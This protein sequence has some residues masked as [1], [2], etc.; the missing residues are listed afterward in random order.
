MM[1]GDRLIGEDDLQAYVDGRLAPDRRDAVEVFLGEHPEEAERIEAHR[2]QRDML[3]ALLKTKIEEPI[4][5][6][7]RVAPIVEEARSRHRRR[8]LQRLR[9]LAAAGAWLIVGS[10]AGWYGKGLSRPTEATQITEAVQTR[11]M[12]VDAFSAYRTFVS[13]VVHP[14]EVDAKQEA[15][16][17]QWLSKRLGAPLSAPN[18][19][20]QGFRLMGGRLLPAG[21]G[22][23]AMFMYDD[24]GGTRLTLYV[25]AGENDDTA[26]RYKGDGK[27]VSAFY[28]RDTGMGYVLTGALDRTRLLAVAEAVYRQLG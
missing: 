21:D 16:L 13:E 23:A 8:R 27:G 19:T 24:D 10:V 20:S 18:L 25:R 5:A 6:R 11:P 12:V 3:R 26:F 15:H 1:Q 4:P 17:V 2:A 22:P 7:L 14:V 28:W 9:A